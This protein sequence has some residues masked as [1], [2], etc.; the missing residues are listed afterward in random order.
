[1]LG[2]VR[3][4]F[5]GLGQMSGKGTIVKVQPPVIVKPNTLIL[6]V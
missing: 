4:I 6:V 3:G 5:P 2:E 1:M